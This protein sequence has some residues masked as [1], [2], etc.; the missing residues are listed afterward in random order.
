MNL[1]L[2]VAEAAAQQVLSIPVYPGLSQDELETVAREVRA[3]CQSR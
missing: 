2:P 1:S 3:L